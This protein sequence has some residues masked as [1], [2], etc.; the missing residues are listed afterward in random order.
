[1]YIFQVVGD[2]GVEVNLVDAEGVTVDAG[3]SPIGE[4]LEIEIVLQALQ[5]IL[6]LRLVMSV[7]SGVIGRVIVCRVQI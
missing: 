5:N 1:M 4:D 6:S 7:E 2:H 3:M